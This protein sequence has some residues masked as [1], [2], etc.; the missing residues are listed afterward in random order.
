MATNEDIIISIL[1]SNG[2]RS[3][4]TMITPKDLIEKCKEQGL[5]NAR[6]VEAA[7]VSL[8]DQDIVEYEMDDNL[9]TSELWL[10]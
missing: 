9:Q 2:C 3:Q 4:D 10:L 7:V 1:K 8:I 6:E 5:S